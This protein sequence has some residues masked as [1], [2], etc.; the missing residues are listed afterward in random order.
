MR[1]RFPAAGLALLTF[2]LL[3]LCA[4]QAAEVIYGCND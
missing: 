4:A 3:P 1:T 2:V